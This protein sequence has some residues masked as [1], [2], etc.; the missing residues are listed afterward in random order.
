MVDGDW[1]DQSSLEVVGSILISARYLDD[2][3]LVIYSYS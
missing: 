3:N 1:E 2:C